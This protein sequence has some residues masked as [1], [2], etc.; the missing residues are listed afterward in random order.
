[1]LTL[2]SYKLAEKLSERL[3]EMSKDLA[4]MVEE[5]NASS[6]S[7]KNSK[8]NDPVRAT[9]HHLVFANIR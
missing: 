6:S 9:S 5:I 7:L 4:S 2:C 3:D 8:T 1:M